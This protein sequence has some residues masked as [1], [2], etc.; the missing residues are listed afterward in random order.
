M[1]FLAKWA[2]V[3]RQG[4]ILTHHGALINTM[5]LDKFLGPYLAVLHRFS[6]KNI[7]PT[8]HTLALE[9]RHVLLKTMVSEPRTYCFSYLAASPA[10]AHHKMSTRLCA[11]QCDGIRAS[12]FL[13]LLIVS[14]VARGRRRLPHRPWAKGSARQ[15]WRTSALSDRVPPR[16]SCVN[17]RRLCQV[18]SNPWI[19]LILVILW[20][21]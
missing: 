10:P 14:A 20:F 4:L 18:A 16:Q 3:S 8:K 15:P 12:F 9:G 17:R 19:I 11:K 1:K 7:S 13:A 21:L 2:A 5:L 6:M